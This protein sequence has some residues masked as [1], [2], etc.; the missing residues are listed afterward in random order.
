MINSISTNL[1]SNRVSANKHPQNPVVKK[2]PQISGSGENVL[3]KYLDSLALINAFQLNDT[4]KKQLNGVH[5]VAVLP[6]NE[7][8]AKYKNDFKH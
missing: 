7:K 1:I 6:Q 8:L 5:C 4:G 2:Q 3:N